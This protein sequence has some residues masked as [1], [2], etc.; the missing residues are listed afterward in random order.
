MPKEFYHEDTKEIVCPYCGYTMSDSWEMGEDGSWT[1][2]ECNNEFIYQRNVFVSYTSRKKECKTHSY[3]VAEF[4]KSTF[5]PVYDKKTD[6]INWVTL[7]TPRYFEVS[8]C[9]NCDKEKF[10]DITQSEY[11]NSQGVEKICT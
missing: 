11:D 4:V 3:K 5:D 7:E 9:E 10:R 2:D 1:C 6:S 8:K